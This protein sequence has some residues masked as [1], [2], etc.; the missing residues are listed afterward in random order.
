MA[1]GLLVG[2]SLGLLGGGGSILTV[3]IFV[4]VLGYG[5]RSSV[6]MSLAVVGTTSAA[7]AVIHGR[8]GNV[9][10][11][12]ALLFCPLAMAGT[13]L[14]ARVAIRLT[15]GFQLTLFALVLL[16][17]AAFMFRAPGPQAPGEATTVTPHWIIVIL[18][19]S[20]V[21]ILTGL[22]GVGGGFLIVP[23]LVLLAGLPMK[24]AIGTSLLVI[25]MNSFA[26]F[27]GYLGRA[28]VDWTGMAAFTGVAI[29]GVLI[30]TR[31]AALVP[32]AR[33]KRIFAVFLVVVAAFI[34][35]EPR[36]AEPVPV[37]PPST[38]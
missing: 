12:A 15:A 38:R 23:A 14:G 9:D 7:G 17:A 20:C 4:Y 6:A 21:G 30:G 31:L 34:L 5:V 26:G 19:G 35:L 13:F 37:Q 10:L 32:Q 29:V 33:L 18:I 1:L 11:R 3:P 16:A 27:T 25:A 36:P 22:V 2:V 28:T 24:Q 8:A